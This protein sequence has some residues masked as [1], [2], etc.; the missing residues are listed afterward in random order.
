MIIP[1]MSTLGVQNEA[2]HAKYLGRAYIALGFGPT[3][4]RNLQW[5]ECSLNDK[6]YT[7]VNV[8]GLGNGKGKTDCPERLLQS[9]R[10]RE[11]INS[12]HTSKIVCGDFNLRPDTEILKL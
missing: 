5:L 12:L 1:I 6:S 3:H 10:I 2:Y 7:I 8:H 9:Q 11:F 4:S